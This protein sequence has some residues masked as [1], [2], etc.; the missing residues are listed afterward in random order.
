[1]NLTECMLTYYIYILFFLKKKQ[2]SMWSSVQ[3]VGRMPKSQLSGAA[4]GRGE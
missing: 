4:K 2:T 1:M 3:R